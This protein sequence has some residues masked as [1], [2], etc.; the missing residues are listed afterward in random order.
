MTGDTGS[1]KSTQL[2]Q[3]IMDSPEIL[4][5][6]NKNLEEK[7]KHKTINLVVTQ[8]RRVAAISMA[9][10]LC[11]ER[12]QKL[13]QEIGYTIRFDDH[14]SEKTTLRYATDGVLVRECLG[15]RFSFIPPRF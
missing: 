12:Q 5:S 1:G 11:Y 8:P 14:C 13:G 10:R 4:E 7:D 15:V 3:F 6:L 2:P 9:K